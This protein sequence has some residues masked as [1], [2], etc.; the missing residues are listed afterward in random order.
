MEVAMTKSHDFPGLS[1]APFDLYLARAK[2]ERAAFVS[3]LVRRVPD[4]VRSVWQHR[5]GSRQSSGGP[6]A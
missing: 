4:L 6:R 5:T 2:A 3:D 1:S